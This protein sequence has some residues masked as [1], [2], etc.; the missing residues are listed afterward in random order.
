MRNV[1]EN[2]WNGWQ[3]LSKEP[4]NLTAREV[5]RER[6]L[7]LVE[8]FNYTATQLDDLKTDLTSGIVVKV[9]EVNTFAEQIA[10]L[11]SE[12]YRIEGLGND[13]N[14]L[15]DQRDLIMDQLSKDMNVTMTEDDSG[16]NIKVGDGD[17][18]RGNVASTRFTSSLFSA[19][20]NDGTLTS[21]EVKG[22]FYSRDKNGYTK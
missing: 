2:F 9:A 10:N 13:A 20:I 17:V 16:F 15:R 7:S 21:G 1:L 5:V 19:M 22:L 8:T 4:D 6:T 18:V 14:D 3:E 11:N 12:I